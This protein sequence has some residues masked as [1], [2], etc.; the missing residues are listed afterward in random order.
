VEHRRVDA[1][2]PSRRVHEPAPL[3]KDR[4]VSL[5]GLVYEVDAVLVRTT[6]TLRFE[7]TLQA[8]AEPAGKA[9]RAD[10]SWSSRSK[11]RQPN[12]G[13]WRCVA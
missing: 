4:T 11:R 6:V 9:A 7:P 3:A 1:G 13:P 12:I 10:A 5:N 8:G 2:V